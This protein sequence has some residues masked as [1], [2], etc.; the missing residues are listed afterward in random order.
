EADAG[1]LRAEIR[2]A[3]RPRAAA[4]IARRRAE[5]DVLRQILIE[6][7]QAIAN[8]RAD[9]R[10]G[11]LARMPAGVP[12]ELSAVVVVIGPQRAHD[13]D[14]VRAFADVPPPIRDHEPALT[15]TAIARVEAHEHVAIAM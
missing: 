4:A 6:R 2:R 15:V 7:A 14:V 3:V 8:P 1:V 11:A 12:G 9:R 13:G 10:K 5:H